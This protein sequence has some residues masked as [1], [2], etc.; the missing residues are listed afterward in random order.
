MADKKGKN[1]ASER[2]K[3][4]NLNGAKWPYRHH[5]V[6]SLCSRGVETQ[7]EHKID[8]RLG[9]PRSQ[10][11]AE[12]ML[13]KAMGAGVAIHLQESRLRHLIN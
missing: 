1:R 7:H 10:P 8:V 2:A 13:I 5:L 6:P 3:N 9:E 11:E 12:R 4:P